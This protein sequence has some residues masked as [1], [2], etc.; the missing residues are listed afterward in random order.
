[1]KELLVCSP[2]RLPLETMVD[3]AKTAVKINPLNHTP[4]QRLTRVV[5]EFIATPERIAVLTTKY[6]GLQGVSLTVGF[7]DNSPTDL[8]KRILQH[9][10]AWAKTANVKFV[11]T[12][13]NPQVRIA[14]IVGQDG[15]YWSYL[16][17]DILHISPKTQT[18][19]LEAFTMNTPESEFH[20][21]VR[22]ETGHTLGFPH[23]HMRKALVDKIDPQKAIEF[24]GRTQGWSEEEVRAQVLTPLEESSLRGTAP[25]PKSIMCYQIPGELTKDGKPIIGGKDIDSSDFGFAATIYPKKVGAPLNPA[26]ALGRAAPSR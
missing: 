2:K 22:H 7:L 18:M 11:E 16:G 23:E 15:G 8:R 5:P 3:A 26:K 14:R 21:V 9:M 20:R 24:F 1:M 13:T 10:N 25:D 19:N 4:L 6:W 12:K 17:T